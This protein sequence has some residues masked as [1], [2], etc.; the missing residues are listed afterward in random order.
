MTH[1]TSLEILLTGAV[2]QLDVRDLR[3]A[4]KDGAPIEVVDLLRLVE[5]LER[6]LNVKKAS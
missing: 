3:L 1:P 6:A 5:D 4:R 2:R